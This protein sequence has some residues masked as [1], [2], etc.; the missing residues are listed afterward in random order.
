MQCKKNRKSQSSLN[1]GFTVLARTLTGM[2]ELSA[3]RSPSTPRTRS[4]RLSHTTRLAG[5]SG[6]P[7]LQ[8]PDMWMP[9]LALRRI[10]DAKSSPAPSLPPPSLP[11]PAP[12]PPPPP[13]PPP[14]SPP[15]LAPTKDVA[16]AR[17]SSVDSAS[18]PGWPMP[19]LR[20]DKE[21]RSPC[22]AGPERSSA[23]RATATAMRRTS[24][25]CDSMFSSAAGH[26][27]GSAHVTATRPRERTRRSIASMKPTA[28]PPP[29]DAASA[30]AFAFAFASTSAF[31]SASQSGMSSHPFSFPPTPNFAT[32]GP[33]SS[34][35]E[36]TAG[37][38]SAAGA[39]AGASSA[40]AGA[41]AAPADGVSKFARGSDPCST[42]TK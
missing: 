21:G 36:P 25:G 2:M 11:L 37:F 17:A 24:S 8:V 26:C 16:L 5:A 27:S 40:G 7:M 28:G 38:A 18:G 20:G 10:H 31:A 9:S 3:T 32:G 42:A 23:R 1:F 22:T 13:P 34:S 41:G 15:P 14:A 30:S 12:A 4:D 33:Q 35:S 29:R 6:G 19:T 39:G